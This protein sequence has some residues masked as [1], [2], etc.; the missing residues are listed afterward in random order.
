MT[1]PVI[2]VAVAGVM[3]MLAEGLAREFVRFEPL[4]AYRLDIIG[5]IG[6][7]AGFSAISFLSVPPVAWGFVVA[8]LFLLLIPPSLRLLQA[9]AILGL[10]FMLGRESMAPGFTWSPYYR[11]GYGEVVEDVY[12]VEVNGIPHQNIWPVRMLDDFEQLYEIPYERSTS[13]PGDV[14][15]VG[16]GTGDDVSI[17]LSRGARSIDA[18]EIDPGL[19]ELGRRLHPDRPYDDPRVAVHINDGRAFLEQSD[20]R[21]DLILFALPDSLTLLSGQSSL[22]LESY[23][24]TIE[25]ME[26]AR[27]HL[28]PGGVFSMYN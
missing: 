16:A 1:L 28:K 10:V 9:V 11:I 15:I 5:A 26:S 27:E 8:A 3:T 13:P 12:A 20:R 21:Y 19:Y 22:R 18:V 23:L 7:I 4:E 2:F 6:G 25:A 17:A 14:L 24:F